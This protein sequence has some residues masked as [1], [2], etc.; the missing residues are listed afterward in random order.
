MSYLELD[1]INKSYIKNGKKF[2]IINNFNLK[3]EQGSLVTFFGPNGCGKTSLFNILSGLDDANSKGIT[4][5][6]KPISHSKVRYIFQ[7]FADSL[8]PWKTCFS[9][10]E[11]PLELQNI[12]Q[13]ERKEIIHDIL[14]KMK[15]TLPLDQYPYQ[16]SGGQ[17]QL[18][19]IARALVT[20]PDLLLMDEPFSALDYTTKKDMEDKLLDIWKKTKVTTLVISHDIEEAVY[21]SN[22]VVVLSKRPASI[23][24]EIV[25]D[26]PENKTQHIKKTPKFIEFYNKVQFAFEQGLKN[27]SS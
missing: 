25:I 9:N 1:H 14:E 6:N 15:I 22:K 26:L 19:C 11:F 23:I 18:T 17:K 4:I 2:Q 7:N 12:E 8:L 3:V 20:K 16:C 27:D 24:D 10:I 13:K 5:N 21:I